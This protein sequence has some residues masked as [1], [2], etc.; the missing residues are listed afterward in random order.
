[1]PPAA[2]VAAHDRHARA[3]PPPARLTGQQI[4]DLVDR[5]GGLLAIRKAAD[6][7]DKAEFY[8]ELSVSE[9]RST[10]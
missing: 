1:V 10:P 5:L 6:P 9:D 3:D 4:K 7:E 2:A 8:R